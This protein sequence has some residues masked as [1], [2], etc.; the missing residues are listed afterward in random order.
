MVLLRIDAR[1]NSPQRALTCPN[2]FE[3]L[4]KSPEEQNSF[5]PQ[6]R[7]KA[8]KSA[9]ETKRGGIAVLCALAPLREIVGFLTTSLARVSVGITAHRAG[10]VSLGNSL[11]A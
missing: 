9:K 8:A 3:A 5:I 10:R 4:E 11:P 7:D 2:G 6:V 1:Q